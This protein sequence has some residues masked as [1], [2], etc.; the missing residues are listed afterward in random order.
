[1]RAR[2]RP[3]SVALGLVLL[4]VLSLLP[5]THEVHDVLEIDELLNETT[6]LGQA[7]T[8]TSGSWPDGANQKVEV[9]VPDGHSIQSL[10]LDLSASPL[11][12]RMSSVLT[13]YGDFA[14]N[15]VYDG[16]DVNKSSLQI[17]P[18][19]WM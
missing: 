8:L 17:L 11:A 13:E 3:V 18:Q 7:E 9:S 1:M 2:A 15:T 5:M 14:G 4:F 19:A 12:N 16:M 6:P 10:D